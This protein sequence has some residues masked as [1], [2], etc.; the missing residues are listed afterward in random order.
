MHIWYNQ[1]IDINLKKNSFVAVKTTAYGIFG[2]RFLMVTLK[3]QTVCNGNAYG[4]IY[5][6]PKQLKNVDRYRVK[7]TEE[8]F[9]RFEKAQRVAMSQLNDLYRKVYDEMGK[10]EA[11]IFSTQQMMLWDEDFTAM[12]SRIINDDSLNAEAAIE[13]TCKEF[14]AIF[15]KVS[16]SYISERCEDIKDV[17]RRLINVLSDTQNITLNNDTPLIIAAH[18]LSPSEIAGFDKDK[19]L[20]VLTEKGSDSSH[21]AILIQKMNIPSLTGVKSVTDKK[22][23]GKNA[24]V[25]C[26]SGVVYIEPDETTLNIL[27]V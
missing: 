6:I 27:S 7:N 4:E 1:Y 2:R 14:V 25:D 8:E 15:K 20:A 26:E 10:A 3:G 16:D 24:A 12:I 22:Y 13:D 23:H 5:V 17:S 18:T 21:A 9:S 11:M 19:I